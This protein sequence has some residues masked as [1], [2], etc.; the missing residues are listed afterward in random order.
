MIQPTAKPGDF[1]W[2]DTNGDGVIT[3]L[4]KQRLGSPLP[5]YTFG[6][7]FSVDYKGFDLSASLN[8]AA[9]NKIFQGLRRIDVGPSPNFQT[10]ALSRWTG[11]G[12]SNVYPRLTI[13]DDNRNFSRFSDFYLEDGDFLRL[14]LITLGYTL[15]T[16]VMNSIGASKV[17]L[18]ATAENLVTLTKYTGYDPEIGGNTFGIDRGYYPQA[19]TF[20]LGVNFQF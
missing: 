15:P 16:K 19:Q 9:G 17:R 2:V 13:A 14:K 1:K 11:E 3:D 5:K 4:D 18:F 8:G 10:K 7:N 12:T 6:F 20:M